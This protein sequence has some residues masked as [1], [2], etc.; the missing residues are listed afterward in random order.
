M[1]L[2]KFIKEVKR[3]SEKISLLHVIIISIFFAVIS[4]I[5]HHGGILNIETDVRL[6]FYLSDIPLLNKIFDSQ[7]LE[8]NRF[9]A[10]ELSYILDFI[11]SKFIELCIENGLPHF[12]SLTHYLFSIA[13]GILIWLF[14]VKELK[15]NPLIGTGWLVLFWTSPS[16]FFGGNYSR[17]G[18]IG[19]AFLAAV[20]FYVLYRAAVKSWQKPDSRISKKH[21]LV[22]FAAIFLIT[23]LDEQGLFLAF[24][25][26]AFLFIWGLF[27]RSRSIWILLFTGIACVLIHLLYRYILAPQLTFILIGYWP[28]FDYQKLPV[29]SIV[30]NIDYISAGFFLFLDT[31]RFLTGN[32]PGIAAIGLL[33]F[34]MFIPFSRLYAGNVLTNH[35]KKVFRLVYIEVLILNGLLIIMNALMYFRNPLIALPNILRT[36]YVLPMNVVMVMTLAVLSAS[37]MKSKITGWL[38]V[39][40]ICMAISGNVAALSGHNDI[41]RKGDWSYIQ[42][43]SSLLKA[44]KNIDSQNSVSDPSVRQSLVYIFFKHRNDNPPADPDEYYQKGI[45][46]AG[47]GQYRQAVENFSI[48]ITQNPDNIR[49]LISRAFIFFKINAYE[50]AIDDLNE[51]ILR[52]PDYAEAYSNRGF[53]HINMGNREPGCRDA[54]KACSLGNCFLL[55]KAKNEGVCR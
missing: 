22:Y 14:C 8:G 3:Y 19:V 20:L 26:L 50:D 28:D 6:P 51:V 2:G 27:F 17:A 13:T 4:V 7:L 36:Y 1:A 12:L 15:L 41:L 16:I 35:D 45:Y 43:S 53:A 10:R 47:H 42:A 32:P 5:N 31:F 38:A 48:A 30:G 37:F 34:L 29:Q 40:M 21:W 33:I 46:Y 54:L 24:A 18:K 25:A 49:A 23:F 11:D 39:I 55:E 44:L 9:R 52:K